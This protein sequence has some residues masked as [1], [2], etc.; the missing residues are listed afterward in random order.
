MKHVIAG[1]D[2]NRFF[3]IRG[4]MEPNQHFNLLLITREDF[5]F[6]INSS[7]LPK[8]RHNSSRF[9]C[10]FSLRRPRVQRIYRPRNSLIVLLLGT[11]DGESF[12]NIEPV[13]PHSLGQVHRSDVEGES[14]LTRIHLMQLQH[15]AYT[16]NTLDIS[17]RLVR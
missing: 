8:N 16:W 11:I 14:E 13:E 7:E 3:I 9:S 1:H 2:A 15:C 6:F 12:Y 10:S 4:E 17:G 5:S